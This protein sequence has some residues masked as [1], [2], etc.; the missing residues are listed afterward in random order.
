MLAIRVIVISLF[1]LAIIHCLEVPV[2]QL[3]DV[4]G[5]SELCAMW[6]LLQQLGGDVQHQCLQAHEVG[7]KLME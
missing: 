1:L 6:V 4:E 5:G 2:H 3:P 7:H